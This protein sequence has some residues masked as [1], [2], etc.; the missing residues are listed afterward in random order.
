MITRQEALELLRE[1]VSD[2]KLVK[3]MLAVEAIMRALARELGQDEELWG[4]TGLL[5]DLD[6][7][8]TKDDFSRHGLR[9]AELLEGKLPPEALHAIMAHN[10]MTGVRP[11]SQLDLALRASDALSGL[12]VATA[13]VMPNKKLAEVK[14]SSLKK[15][16]KAKDFARGANRDRIRLCEQL[17]ISLERFLELGLEAM[18]AIASELGL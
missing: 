7:E 16:F 11:E 13:L 10:D 3:H 14:L 9:S 12:V 17:G 8:E 4:L 15:K 1:H 18:K 2:D 5:H 6:Y